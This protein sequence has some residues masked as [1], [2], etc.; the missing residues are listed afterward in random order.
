MINKRT[1][2][3]IL[4]VLSFF[5]LQVSA[6]VYQSKAKINFKGSLYDKKSGYELPGEIFIKKNN[7]WIK[8]GSTKYK[9]NMD[10]KY[11]VVLST[12]M[13]ALSIRSKGYQ[14][15]EIPLNFHGKFEKLSEI[16]FD[17]PMEKEG[18]TNKFQESYIAICKNDNSDL[19]ATYTDIHFLDEQIHC[20]KEFTQ[21]VKI[22]T[23]LPF[24]VA[25]VESATEKSFHILEATSPKGKVLTRNKYFYLEGFSFIDSNIYPEA[26]ISTSSNVE[27][28]E[29]D[30]SLINSNEN[31]EPKVET[32]VF[33]FSPI[34]FEQSKYELS[35]SIQQNLN[36]L[37]NYLK[38]NE[39][40]KLKIKG[41][42]ENI[43][44]SKRNEKLAEYR[45]KAVLSFLKNKGLKEERFESTW[46]TS[47]QIESKEISTENK[48]SKV[49][50]EEI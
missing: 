22:G 48:E 44:D 26:E 16:S 49:L 31:G 15:I 10:S 13:Q 29:S 8:L 25:T 4:V 3:S 9:N 18:T 27:I 21:Q 46:E 7:E 43:G 41:F 30:S 42:A 11:S 17:F 35:T 2:F 34:V 23:V 33:K 5:T 45:A 14:T 40:I 38:A 20:K 12:D 1:I 47:A 36:D 28:P 39:H 50:I 32:E 6:F 19:S 24:S 37:V